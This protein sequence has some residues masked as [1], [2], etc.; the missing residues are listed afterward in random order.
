MTDENPT[1]SPPSQSLAPSVHSPLQYD[2]P[3]V[4]VRHKSQF[5]ALHDAPMGT[6]HTCINALQLSDSHSV[7]VVQAAPTSASGVH[8]SVA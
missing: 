4:R 3:F 2:V 5:V 7:L 8:A 6:R 1:H